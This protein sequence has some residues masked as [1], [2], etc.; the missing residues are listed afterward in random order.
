MATAAR[1]HNLISRVQQLEAEVPAIETTFLSQTHNFSFLT[2]GGIDWHP[3]LQSE[4]KLVTRGDLPRFIM[5]SYGEC[6]GPPRLFLLDKYDVAGAGACLKRYTDPSFFTEDYASSVTKTTEVVHREKRIRKVRMQGVGSRNGETPEVLPSHTKLHQLFLEERIEDTC[7]DPARLVKL[8]KKQL[9]GYAVEAKSGRSYMEKILKMP[10]PDYK[11]V[12]ETSIVPQ[13]VKLMSDDTSETRIKIL[14]ISSNAPRKRS[15][16]NDNTHS[17]WIEQESELNPYSE[18]DRETNRYLGKEHDQISASVTNEM[19][20]N[21]LKLHDEKELVADEQEKRECI[22][23]GYRSDDAISEVDDYMDALATVESECESDNECRLQNSVLNAQN[24][25]D[26]NTYQMDTQFSDSQSFGDSFTSEEISSTEQDRNE[27]Q[28]QARFPDSQSV[29]NSTREIENRPSNFLLQTVELQKTCGQFVMQV[30]TL[31]QGG[32]ISHSRPVSSSGSSLMEQGCLLFPSDLGAPSLVSPL[33]GTQLDETPSSPLE[34][35]LRLE[36]DE[37]RKCLAESIASVSSTF[38]PIKDDAC[39]V[40]SYDN[41]SLNNLHV[42]DPHIHSNALLQDSNDI[43]FSNE[44][45]SGDPSDIKVL[46]SKSLNGYSSEIL[47]G[48]GIGS[49]GG[50]PVCLSMEAHPNSGTK[51]LLDDRDLKSEDDKIATQLNSDDLFPV[52]DTTLESSFTE[53]PCSS[54][55]LGNPHN[56]PNSA[57][58]EVLYRDQQSNFEVMPS[59]MPDDE[60]SGSTCSSDPI[61][62]EDHIKRPPCDDTSKDNHVM[63]NDNFSVKVQSEDQPVSAL[64]SVNIAEND[65]SIVD[66]LASNSVSSPSRDLSDLHEPFLCSSD[67]HLI[68]MESHDVDLTKISVDLNADKIESKVEPSPDIIFSPICSLTTLEESLSTF[69]DPHEKE[70]EVNEAVP[71][72]SLAELTAHEKEMEVNEAVPG[73]SLAELTAHEVEDQPEIA[74]TDVQLNLNRPVPCDPVFRI[75]NNFQH[76]SLKEKFQYGSSINDMEMVTLCSEQDSQRS[77]SILACQN[78][79]QNSKDSLS[80]PL[81]DQLEPEQQDAKFLLRNEESYTSEKFQAQQM[82][83]SNQ[84]EQER[85]SDAASKFTAEVHPDEPSHDSSPKSS[86]ETNP[87]K[88]VMDPLKP[89]LSDLFPKETKTNVEETPPMPPLPPM[90]WR[91]SKVQVA[92]L[93]SQREEKEASQ[94]SFQP[95]QPVNHDD[96]AQF[97]LATPERETLLSHNPFFPVIALESR[98]HRHS[99]GLSA[100][101]SERASAIPSQFPVMLNETSMVE[102]LDRPPHGYAVASEEQRVLNSSPCPPTLPEECAISGTDPIFQQEKP[103][104]SLS[105]LMEETSLE[106]QTLEQSSINLKREQGDPSV[107]PVSPSGFVQPNHSPALSFDA[108]TQISKFHSE[109]QNGKPKNKLTPPQAPSNDVVAALD[110]SR[111]RKVSERVR[112]QIAPKEDEKDSLLEQIRMKSFNLKP[113]VPKRPSIL[114]PKTNLR[115]AA[116]L[117]K[118]NSIRQALAGSDEDDDADSWSDS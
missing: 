97:G 72:E 3:N 102:S 35:H 10:S 37:D 90:Q 66:C 46:Q 79:I 6:R 73:E 50:D 118:A 30:D 4:Q 53:E 56:G 109:M 94:A 2:N 84:L 62:D 24:V 47:V 100:G 59:I 108:S 1:G 76:S 89:L 70:I 58:I 113:A 22:L 117:E 54:H 51:V 116:I 106:V 78:D 93:V 91:T 14:E 18:M 86:G 20:S 104:Q 82:Q 36:D 75:F 25:T 69:A 26:S 103:T 68:E 12:Y 40:V 92:S 114:G 87:T 64:S 21:N 85:V 81:N 60:I 42:C 65:A 49:Q 110:K 111:L 98:D 96:K 13:P 77:G 55:T 88:H 34:L 8:R 45:E 15:L 28:V 19:S 31:D 74:F 105:K 32:A 115:V 83:L 7:S 112:P 61:E 71:G 23:D 44:D 17:S 33:R 48:G 95:L 57:E 99:A 5:D 29:G 107:L 11:M 101:V 67:S 9:D 39:I 63:V 43:N 52:A 80:P 27:E 41:N 38:T 16:G